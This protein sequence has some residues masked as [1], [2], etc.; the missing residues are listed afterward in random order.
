MLREYVDLHYKQNKTEADHDQ[1]ANICM[2]LNLTAEMALEE[3][4]TL[5]DRRNQWPAD[6]CDDIG[7][8]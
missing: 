1:M 2:A 4:Q 7:A 5:L 3:G 8:H 6:A